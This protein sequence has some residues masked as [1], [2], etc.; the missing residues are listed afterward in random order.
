MFINNIFSLS[1]I[2]PCQLRAMPPGHVKKNRAKAYASPRKLIAPKAT[3]DS[4]LELTERQESLEKKRAASLLEPTER[5]KCN[6]IARDNFTEFTKT[7]RLVLTDA[8]GCNLA[9]RI[10]DDRALVAAGKLDSAT[11]QQTTL[12]S[13]A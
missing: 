9:K 3:P 6:K 12:T 8:N 13:C 4:L 10:E 5:A 2:S 11:G 7:Q 1:W